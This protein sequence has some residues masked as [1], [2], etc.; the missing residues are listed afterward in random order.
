MSRLRSHQ[1][2]VGARFVW[3]TCWRNARRGDPVRTGLG[4]AAA[5]CLAA[6]ARAAEEA[7]R[8]E[9][10]SAQV[11]A[12]F[13]AARAGYVFCHRSSIAWRALS[14]RGWSISEVGAALKI[15]GLVV[16]QLPSL[17][18]EVLRAE[19]AQAVS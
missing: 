2:D 16:D 4:D 18:A 6:R 11:G 13:F 7:E 10:D 19:R 12:S 17:A 3:R 8:L 15:R 9:D 14:R 1:P 5:A